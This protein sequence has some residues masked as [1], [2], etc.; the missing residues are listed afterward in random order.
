M[1]RTGQSDVL[2]NNAKAAKLHNNAMKL[3]QNAQRFTSQ[4]ITWSHWNAQWIHREC[5]H[6]KWAFDKII[7]KNI[8][9]ESIHSTDTYQAWHNS[10]DFWR[11]PTHRE[12]R[13]HARTSKP[14]RSCRR[15]VLAAEFEYLDD[16]FG[17][18]IAR[19][20]VVDI[21]ALSGDA[22]DDKTRAAW[23]AKLTHNKWNRIVHDSCAKKPYYEGS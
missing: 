19:H 10:A 16:V 17:V 3:T 21:G 12:P 11:S 6:A 23:W 8:R 7:R 22:I 4:I 9:L 14:R 13:A 2:R 15:R 18:C 20:L 5:E 1:L